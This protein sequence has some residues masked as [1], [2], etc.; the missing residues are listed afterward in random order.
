MT[1]CILFLKEFDRF[2][3]T[4]ILKCELEDRKAALVLIITLNLLG[5]HHSSSS[6]VGGFYPSVAWNKNNSVPWS[7][8][9]GGI[10]KLLQAKLKYHINSP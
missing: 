2:L 4:R 3:G 5:I 8:L 6:S 10:I 7:K 9:K 1:V